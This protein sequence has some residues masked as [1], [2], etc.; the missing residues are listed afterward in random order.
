VPEEL[1]MGQTTEISEQV[2]AKKKESEGEAGSLG[3]A[4]AVYAI[5][6]TYPGENRSLL[7]GCG[8]QERSAALRAL[9]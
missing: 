3:V 5:M 6:N 1:D 8:W 4:V 2:P 7:F 9:S